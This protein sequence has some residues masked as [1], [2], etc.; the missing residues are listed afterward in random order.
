MV[1]AGLI[2]GFIQWS[3][4]IVLAFGYLGVFI[5]GFIGTVS[6]VLPTPAFLA[7]FVAGS[8]LNPW[9]VGIVSG[10]GMAIGELTGYGFGIVGKKVIEKKHK[11]WLKKAKGWFEGHGAFWVII[12]FSAT[13]LPDDVVGFLSGMI[14]YDIKKFFVATFIGKTAMNIALAWAGF[15]GVQWVLGLFG[16]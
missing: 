13:P 15:Y 9:L 6:I 2:A 4:E 1:L 11:K 8:V 7:I 10:L 5:I 16:I 12:L 14:K 3:Q